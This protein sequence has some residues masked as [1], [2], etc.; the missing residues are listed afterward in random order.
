M[1]LNSTVFKDLPVN[2]FSEAIDL[3]TAGGKLVTG[4]IVRLCLK[5]NLALESLL[6]MGID[7]SYLQG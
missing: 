5:E 4:I 3:M 2:S 1:S 6:L 7:T